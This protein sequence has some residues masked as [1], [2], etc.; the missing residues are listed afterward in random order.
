[1]TTGAI[2]RNTRVIE[3]TGGKATDVM[4]Y[5]AIFRSRDV[6][7][8][9]TRGDSAVMAGCAIACDALMSEDRGKKRPGG[10]TKVAILRG[11]QMIHRRTLSDGINTIVTTFAATGHTSMIKYTS[12]KTGGDMTHGAIV[13]GGNMIH[14]LTSRVRAIMTR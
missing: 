4:A 1:M 11:G 2:V 14:R 10:M 12:G 3:H 9:F 5:A 8:G 6:R 7:R 13:V